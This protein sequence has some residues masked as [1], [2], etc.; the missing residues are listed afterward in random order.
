MKTLIRI[1]ILG[2]VIA[3]AWAAFFIFS[4]GL[5]TAV[6]SGIEKTLAFVLQVDVSLREIE[7]SPVSGEVALRGLKIGNPDGFKTE[8]AFYLEEATVRA[9]LA[10]FTGDSP[11]IELISI[12][13]AK[14]TLEQGLRSSNLSTLIES[15]SRFSSGEA[16]EA[17][18]AP[19]GETADASSKQI[20]ID[21]IV[22][23]NTRVSLSAPILMGQEVGYTLSTIEMTD[24][25]GESERVSIAE[26]LRIFIK[27][28]L[29]VSLEEGTGV[30][31]GDLLASLT[32]G[33]GGVAGG[34]AG[35]VEKAIEG[36]GSQVGD[37]GEGLAGATG[38]LEE[39]LKG[40]V[41]S[42]EES[43]KG[44]TEELEKGLGKVGDSLKG[45][46]GRD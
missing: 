46:L 27:K 10:S 29:A 5:N 31:P 35:G 38:V 40:S 12:I 22:L 26:A 39:G 32:G 19:D 43:L 45:L 15:A 30:M 14:V 36:I 25:G 33:L 16:G 34:I 21:R 8:S 9:D 37:I 13:G 23:E 6:R 28:I 2:V 20:K 17:E 41:E 11:T 3:V 24:L 44:A 18:E 42:V 7:I 1:I 4:G